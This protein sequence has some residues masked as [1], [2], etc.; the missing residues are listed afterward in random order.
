M[1]KII[2]LLTF[3]CL[4]FLAND[5][6][7]FTISSNTEHPRLIYS[8]QS[9]TY[10]KSKFNDSSYAYYDELQYRKSWCDTRIG[11]GLKTA[12]YCKWYIWL[13]LI[14]KGTP[15]WRSE[16]RDWPITL[17]VQMA[18]NSQEV[19]GEG[20]AFGRLSFVALV[21]DW[22]YDDLTDSQRKTIQDKLV[23]KNANIPLN[24]DKLWII[25]EDENKFW[26]YFA[27]LQGD[28][29]SFV[30]GTYSDTFVKSELERY[31]NRLEDDCIPCL[32]EISPNGA[33][34]GYGGVKETALLLAGDWYRRYTDWNPFVISN[35]FKNM[36]KFWAARLRSDLLWARMPAKYNTSNISM[37]FF[38]YFGGLLNDQPSLALFYKYL[39]LEDIGGEEALLS[40]A[41]CP[42]TSLTVTPNI[43]FDTE[44]YD[45]GMGFYLGRSNWNLDPQGNA[46]T[47]QV[48]FFAGPNTQNHKT[49]NHFFIT[50]GKLPILSDA[51]LYAG[52]L[53]SNYLF[54]KNGIAHNIPLIKKTGQTSNSDLSDC[55]GKDHPIVYVGD[56]LDSDKTIGQ[57]YW[58]AC[59]GTYGYRGQIT[60]FNQ[61]DY[62]NTTDFKFDVTYIEADATFAYGDRVKK[63]VRRF[64]WIRPI[65]CILIQDYFEPLSGDID[66]RILNHTAKKPEALNPTNVS[67]IKGSTNGGVIKYSG[68]NTVKITNETAVAYF[69]FINNNDFSVKLIGGPNSNGLYWKQNHD[70]TGNCS[71]CGTTYYDSYDSNISYE[72]YIEEDGKN[73]VPSRCDNPPLKNDF[74][75]RNGS[76]VDRDHYADPACDWRFQIEKIT[77]S[78]IQVNQII[79]IPD[80]AIQDGTVNNIT[81]S[82]ISRNDSTIVAL[83]GLAPK[84]IFAKN[85]IS[86]GGIQGPTDPTGACCLTNGLCII[87]T[88]SACE[89]LGIY[90]GDNISCSPSPCPLPVI[91]GACCQDMGVC[92][93]IT[94]ED[95]DIIEG[96]FMGNGTNCL[97]CTVSVPPDTVLVPC[98]TIYVDFENVPDNKI[99]KILD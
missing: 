50:K 97:D 79:Y 29:S 52:D 59:D 17:A 7:A 74:E 31:K 68:V 56:Q 40:M 36:T 14:T 6:F 94:K 92:T 85:G 81:Y 65:N 47:L 30:N 87:L 22:A 33:I 72:F 32:D 95:C 4:L 20:S 98:D 43:E 88:R 38:A 75:N 28:R 55:T 63:Y 5:S 16:Y 48:G 60:K 93:H 10:I 89:P 25:N 64:M 21:Y 15:S 41:Y 2:F 58:P 9:V 34:D 70:P 54:Y 62:V 42:N 18:Q 90:L 26:H 83:E 35:H 11:N 1:K 23:S 80:G 57:N 49:Q 44:Y 51:N 45:E 82:Y 69:N 46:N 91:L 99:I 73:Y 86:M 67:V 61:F 96:T 78:P 77:S 13:H 24:Y 71:I 76:S 8:K 39:D 27:V 3:F 12:Y 37:H 53:S 19:T 84:I 66:V